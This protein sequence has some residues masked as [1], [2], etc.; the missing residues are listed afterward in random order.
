[1]QKQ[2][3]FTIIELIVVIAIIAILAAVVLVN[4]TQ[5]ITKSKNAAIEGNMESLLT[6]GT[7]YYDNASSSYLGFNADTSTGCEGPINSAIAKAGG[8]LSCSLRTDNA[9]WCA[10]A[11][12][13]P[14]SDTPDNSTF[15]GDSTGIKKIT[16]TSCEDEC[17]VGDDEGYCH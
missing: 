8:S 13:N 15:C 14:A 7:A 17:K 6:N 5:Y 12:L 16:Q 10:C 1:M 3:G 11:T 9:A 4:V 2:K